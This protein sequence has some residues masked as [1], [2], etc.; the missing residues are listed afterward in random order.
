MKELTQDTFGPGQGFVEFVKDCVEENTGIPK[1]RLLDAWVMWPL[2]A[3]GLA[4]ENPVLQ[5]SLYRKALLE[6]LE[7][8]MAPRGMDS[9]KND[10][11]AVNPPSTPQLNEWV[12]QFQ[13][14]LRAVFPSGGNNS[15]R[16]YWMWLIA[17]SGCKFND[18]FG[19]FCLTKAEH[20]SGIL[21]NSLRHSHDGV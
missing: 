12:K 21:I 11:A 1:D 15:L 17:I 16:P 7:K 10:T 6:Y 9:I 3:G 5:Y 18:T 14:M 13:N 19:T 8:S 4:V 2:S 20:V